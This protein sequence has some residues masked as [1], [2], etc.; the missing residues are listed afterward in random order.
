MRGAKLRTAADVDEALAGLGSDPA[1][2]AADPT[3]HVSDALVTAAG[4]RSL[5]R[6]PAAFAPAG[7]TADIA[8]T[9]GW[10]FGVL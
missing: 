4:M 6:D 7:L 10:T 3:D 1:R 5:A 9:E 2:L 8:R